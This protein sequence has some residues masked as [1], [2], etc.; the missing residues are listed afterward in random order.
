M[1]LLIFFNAVCN[2]LGLNKKDQY[3]Q[4][5]NNEFSKKYFASIKKLRGKD[6][7]IQDIF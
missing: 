5:N 2:L 1:L 6:L 4:K 3:N 7:K